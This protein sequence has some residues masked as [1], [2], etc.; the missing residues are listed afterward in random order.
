MMK[1]GVS[2][3]GSR[4][5]RHVKEDMADIAAHNCNFVVHTFSEADLEFYKGTMK[6]IAE[7]SRNCGLEVWLDPWAVGGVFG[8]EAYSKFIAANLD[9][10]EISAKTGESL[11]AACLNN[12]KF[13]GFMLGW[14]DAALWIGPDVLFWD[15]PHFYLYPLDEMERDPA[16]WACRCG[17]CRELFEKRFGYLMPVDINDDVKLFKE[18]S[19]I[20]FLKTMC[21]Y[22]KCTPYPASRTPIKN[23]V[24]FLPFKGALGGI[25][26]W[27]KA[28][29]IES[30]DI[31]GT[32]PYWI[33][34]GRKWDVKKIVGEFSEKIYAL[35]KEYGKEGQIW[36]LNFRIKKGTEKDI[37]TAVEVAYNKG[38]RNLAAWSYLG[39]GCM[40]SLAS[41]DPQKVW[42][43]LGEAFAGLK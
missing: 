17:T 4:I 18:D 25:M 31:I 19:I 24:C 5:Q 9:T 27:S 43:T 11:P 26:D 29:R 15:E 2:Y 20:E 1:T 22:A 38:I 34:G 16:L 8:G 3:F 39:T 40:S 14:I 23:A 12:K 33:L 13:R 30:L 6:E 42:A 36:I 10:R 28:A 37:E 35:S 41:D 7:I 32:D 21:D